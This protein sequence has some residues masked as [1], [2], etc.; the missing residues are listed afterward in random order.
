M[1][2]LLRNDL[3]A[4]GTDPKMPRTTKPAKDSTC[5]AEK[6][7]DESSMH[8]SSS[9][10]QEQDPEVFL[11]PSQAQILPN[12]PMPYIEG[13]KMDWTVN[14]GLYHRLLKWLLKCENILQ[15]DP[16]MLPE[17]S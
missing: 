8:V 15:C 1:L 16:A 2:Y 9:L 11:Q 6:I 7:Q 5:A 17:A 10:D 3:L 12:M 4:Q 14:D 13:P